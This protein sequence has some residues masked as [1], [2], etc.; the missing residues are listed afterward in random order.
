MAT[1]INN[2]SSRPDNIVIRDN[3]VIED[4]E[5]IEAQLPAFMR[6]YFVYLR[7]SVAATTR[8]AYLQDIK[9]FCN[10]LVDT[11]L[12]KKKWFLL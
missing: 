11:D 8:R 6:D 10:Y 1:K 4:C 5:S 9:F 2:K 3:N 12:F 7:G